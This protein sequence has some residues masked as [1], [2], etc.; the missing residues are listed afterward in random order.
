MQCPGSSIHYQDAF[1]CGSFQ[2]GC[3]ACWWLCCFQHH[4]N[5]EVSDNSG[6]HTS[7]VRAGILTETTQCC[8]VHST[9]LTVN[10]KNS[11]SL[12]G[13][14]SLSFKMRT[15]FWALCSAENQ[16][17]FPAETLSVL[18]RCKNKPGS[19]SCLNLSVLCLPDWLFWWCPVRAVAE[20]G[21]SHSPVPL[22]WECCSTAYS[23]FSS[24][25]VR[26]L[27]SKWVNHRCNFLQNYQL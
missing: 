23:S 13:P 11:F 26:C 25:H 22:C 27:S 2:P 19:G 5:P 16:L 1:D 8:L 9:G 17:L 18:Q 12:S 3:M 10:C 24:F 14:P 21:R 15:I 20:Q 4:G 6:Q 7:R